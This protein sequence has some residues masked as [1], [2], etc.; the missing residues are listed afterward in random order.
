[1]TKILTLLIFICSVAFATDPYPRNPNIDIKQYT[2]QLEVNDSTD[3]IAGKASVTI[4]FKKQIVDFLLDLAN[5]NTQGPRH[6]G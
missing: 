4:L 2:F 6:D 1:M 3:V 5:K